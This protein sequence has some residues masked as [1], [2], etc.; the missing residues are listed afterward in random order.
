M[1]YDNVPTVCP[2]CG[3]GC[4]LFLQVLDQEIIGVLPVKSHAVS[5]G[6]LCIKGWNAHEFVTHK[7]RL[8]KPLVKTNGRFKEISWDEALGIVA[9]KLKEHAPEAVAALSSAK[10]TNE[11][12]FS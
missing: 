2:Y 5:Q 9:Q 7:D 8:L 11:E 6:K 4:R 3:A 10:C 12:N 1:K